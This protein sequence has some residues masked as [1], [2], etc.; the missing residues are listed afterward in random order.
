MIRLIQFE[1]YKLIRQPRIWLTFAVMAVLMFLINLGM[2]IDGQ[3]MIELL[4]KPLADQFIISG[5][6]INGNLIAYVSLNM[7]WVHIPILLVIV[8]GDLVSGEFDAGTIRLAL[9]STYTRVQWLTAKVAAA[10]IYIF[11]FMLLSGLLMY[12]PAQLVFGSGGGIT[13][14]SDSYI[15]LENGQLFHTN[16]FTRESEELPSVGREKAGKFFSELT[17]LQLAKM[18]FNHPGNLYYFLESVDGDIVH[19]VTWGSNDYEAPASC[20]T[21]YKKLVATIK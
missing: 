15:L 20:K 10:F 5:N 18:D 3:K 14:G 7:L 2:A 9:C 21:L 16:S 8:T 11:C 1:T 19:R 12:I 17:Q 6:L 13:G 4:I